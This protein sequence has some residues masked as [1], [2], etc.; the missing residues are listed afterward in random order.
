M[1]VDVSRFRILELTTSLIIGWIRECHFAH[2]A[3]ASERITID[4]YGLFRHRTST[5]TVRM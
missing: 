3:S 1:R 2:Q 5:H 4:L